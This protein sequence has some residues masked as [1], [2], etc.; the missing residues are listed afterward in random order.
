M[1]GKFKKLSRQVGKGVAGAMTAYAMSQ[2]AMAVESP[3]NMNIVLS[4]S[5]A[6]GVPTNTLY[7]DPLSTINTA[8]I[9]EYVRGG[10]GISPTEV[11]NTFKTRY[12]DP[13][14]V[15]TNQGPAWVITGVTSR[16]FSPQGPFDGFGVFANQVSATNAYTAQFQ[17]DGDLYTG[18]NPANFTNA[19]GLQLVTFQFNVD[20]TKVNQGALASLGTLST[21]TWINQ[22]NDNRIMNWD[23]NGGQIVFIPEPSTYALML[24]GLGALA[25]WRRIRSRKLSRVEEAVLF[26]S[27]AKLDSG[28]LASKCNNNKKRFGVVEASK[29]YSGNKSN[30]YLDD[31]SLR[32][33][34]GK[35]ITPK[36]SIYHRRAPSTLSSQD[37]A[38]NN[39]RMPG[40]EFEN[41]RENL[42]QR[43]NY[44]AQSRPV[45]AGGGN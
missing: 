33:I 36:K 9:T 25:G 30:P 31:K 17:T 3:T 40:R 32:D 6:L 20:G 11:V 44:R 35:A 1:V 26:A 5:S 2:G 34:V 19:P 10:T 8:Y 23:A 14:Y 43:V 15:S 21:R 13:D 7:V 38:R 12:F 22:N 28:D 18:P 29:I 16:A 27:G 24:T 45:H 4:L 42:M 37:Y 39:A 41:R